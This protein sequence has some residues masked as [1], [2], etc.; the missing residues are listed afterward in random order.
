MIQDSFKK[1]SDYLSDLFREETVSVSQ[2]Q[3]LRLYALYK[4]STKGPLYEPGS[5]EPRQ[6]QP[7]FLQ[8]RD[9]AKWDAWNEIGNELTIEDAMIEYI[10]EVVRIIRG[11]DDPDTYEPII[12]GFFESS[13]EMNEVLSGGNNGSSYEDSYD[14]S[15]DSN[16]TDSNLKQSEKLSLLLAKV[17]EIDFKLSDISEQIM[18]TRRM[19]GSSAVISGSLLIAMGIFLI[20]GRRGPGRSRGRF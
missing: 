4:Y 7:S 12:R 14:S 15:N 19:S 17:K 1:A 8:I 10:D 3:Q 13:E 18:Q 5:R 6:S 20:F 16:Y 11:L 9:R 2:T